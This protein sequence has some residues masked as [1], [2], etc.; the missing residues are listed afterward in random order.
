MAM[1]TFNVT[2]KYICDNAHNDG[3]KWQHPSGG[4]ANDYLHLTRICSCIQKIYLRE[5]RQGKEM[6]NQN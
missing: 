5:H 3:E 4:Y 2:G 6:P 1:G